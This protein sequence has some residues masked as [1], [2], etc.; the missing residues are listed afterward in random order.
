MMYAK[1]LTCSSILYDPKSFYGWASVKDIRHAQA[2]FRLLGL[3]IG[4]QLF[5]I[6]FP[7]FVPSAYRSIDI[8]CF[9]SFLYSPLV[10]GKTLETENNVDQLTWIN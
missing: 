7:L 2:D 9:V 8:R 10:L 1:V 5:V 4:S 6:L 3:L